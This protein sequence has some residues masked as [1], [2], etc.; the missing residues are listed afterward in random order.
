MQNFLH[1]TC[2][3]VPKFHA[4]FGQAIER[5]EISKEVDQG[6]TNT[7]SRRSE[8]KK[9]LGRVDK[10]YKHEGTDLNLVM[11]DFGAHV[12]YDAAF[13]DMRAMEHEI[14]KICSFYINKA[15]PLLDN[16][17]RNMYPAVDRLRILDEVMHCENKYQEAKLEY[18]QVL[19][20]CYEHTSD[21]LEQQRLIQDVVDE[22]ARRPR[23]NL[24]GTHFKDSYTT[25]V[26]CYKAKT[27]LVKDLVRMVMRDEFKVNTGVREYV[28]KSY[29]LLHE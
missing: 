13:S 18:V 2:P 4:T 8:S 6:Q 16:D 14:L 5:Q 10:M 20:E 15:E 21:I 19:M 23:L 26:E 12:L 3:L 24:S 22:M 29:R 7:D 27:A 11:D 17:L 9:F 25:E 1:S 28:E